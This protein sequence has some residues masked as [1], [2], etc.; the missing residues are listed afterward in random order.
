MSEKIPIG[1]ALDS[2]GLRI[3]LRDG[4]LFDGAVISYRI[5]DADGDRRVG[6]AW[7]DG[8][9]WITRRA[10]IEIARDAE[11]IEPNAFQED[12]G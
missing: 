9:D 8:M 6:V 7:T 5:L 12:D 2:G 10:L 3:T 1:N 11:R 4:E